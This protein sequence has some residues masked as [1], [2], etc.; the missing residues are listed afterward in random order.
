VRETPD[1]HADNSFSPLVLQVMCRAEALA[2][3]RMVHLGR[4]IPLPPCI[5]RTLGLF[6]EIVHP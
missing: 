4:A 6:I 5:A 3:H 2:H 1:I